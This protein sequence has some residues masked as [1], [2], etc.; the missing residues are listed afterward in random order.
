MPN[1]ACEE[2]PGCGQWI[3]PTKANPAYKGKWIAPLIDNP[4]YIGEWKAKQIPNPA[5]F[6]DEHPHKLPAMVRLRERFHCLS[7]LCSG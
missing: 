1:P 2:G 4:E 5:Y 3:R 6:V 7:W